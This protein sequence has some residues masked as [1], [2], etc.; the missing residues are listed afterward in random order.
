MVTVVSQTV[1]PFSAC[2]YGY[3][4]TVPH[5][6]AASASAA[7]DVGPNL[8]PQAHLPSVQHSFLSTPSFNH[9]Q[10]GPPKSLSFSNSLLAGRHELN[11]LTYHPINGIESPRR[12]RFLGWQTVSI[13]GP[14][15]PEDGCWRSSA[16]PLPAQQVRT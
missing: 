6:P 3:S 14:S 7:T 10:A 15:R 11:T 12:F 4:T 1:F 2:C 5:R 13:R 9:L 8:Y 16:G